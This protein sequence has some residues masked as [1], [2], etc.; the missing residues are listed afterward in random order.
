[1]TRV[2]LADGDEVLLLTMSRSLA[3]FG[4]EVVA[5]S[6]PAA[7]RACL[8]EQ[9]FDLAVIDQRWHSVTRRAEASPASE[10]PLVL[11]TSSWGP[12]EGRPSGEGRTLLRKPFSSLELLSTIRRELGLSHIPP[13]STIDALHRAHA[14]QQTVCLRARA[15]G[16]DWLAAEACIY[17]E[18]GELVHAVFGA[19]DGVRAL[20]EIVRRRAPVVKASPEAAPAR[21]I[22]R[23]FRSLIF[24]ILQE[25]DT[26]PPAAAPACSGASGLDTNDD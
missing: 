18:G 22:Q 4:I 16:E 17:L 6:S 1:M 23:P 24:E 3:H 14:Q 25:L 21:S 13:A 7:T 15:V 26:A 12:R 9:R 19:L 2:L 11:M 10:T 5:C 20:K 8:E